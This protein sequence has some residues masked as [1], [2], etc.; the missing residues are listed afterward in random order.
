[1]LASI[2]GTDITEYINETSYEVNQEELTEEFYD[3]NHKLH[4]IPLAKKVRGSFQMVFVK[5]EDLTNF[6]NL[7]EANKTGNLLHI[8]LWISNLNRA[9]ELDVYFE[10]LS[11]KKV[12]I[13]DRYEFHKF[14][15]EIEEA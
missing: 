10:F 6:V 11:K 5:P 2:N 4:K 7:M 8:T 1:M 13:S 15:V 14:K 12:R 3:G 9:A